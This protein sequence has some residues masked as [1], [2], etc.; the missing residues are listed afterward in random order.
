VIKFHA[1]ENDIRASGNSKISAS[2]IATIKGLPALALA[3]SNQASKNNKV[4]VTIRLMTKNLLL[5]TAKRA[6]PRSAVI[7]KYRVPP[8]LC[9]S[10]VPNFVLVMSSQDI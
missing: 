7:I 10:V 5:R 3:T 6:F 4:E 8:K 9:P 1:T 2:E